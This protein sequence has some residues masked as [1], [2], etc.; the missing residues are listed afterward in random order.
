MESAHFKGAIREAPQWEK[1]Q[2]N[3]QREETA[4]WGKLQLREA[5]DMLQCYFCSDT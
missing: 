5:C 1:S 3:S 4:A 2:R